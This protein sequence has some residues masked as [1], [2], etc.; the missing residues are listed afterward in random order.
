MRVIKVIG[1][2]ISAG[3]S[4]GYCVSSSLTRK[5]AGT[6]ENPAAN[7]YPPI[8]SK[9]H[10]VVTLHAF[11]IHGRVIRPLGLLF[12]H[13]DIYSYLLSLGQSYGPP[14]AT[15]TPFLPWVRGKVPAKNEVDWTNSF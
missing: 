12:G 11:T 6:A 14:S 9:F 3:P 5:T 13:L 1:H 10:A 15:L 8:T 4:A 7:K 2:C